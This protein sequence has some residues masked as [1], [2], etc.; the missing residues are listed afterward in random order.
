MF[1]FRFRLQLSFF[2]FCA[3]ILSVH[4]QEIGM[5][6]DFFGYVDNREFQAPYT[7][8][9]TILGTQLS[10]QLYLK[11]DENHY[12]YGGINYNQDFGKH[13]EN[14]SRFNPIA[15]YNYKSEKI[16]FALGFIPRYERLK[17]IPK[18]VL[19]DTFM[20]DRPNIEGMYFQY[21]GDNFKQAVFIDWLSEQ[22]YSHREQFVAGISGF[23]KWGLLYFKNDGLLYHNALTSNDEIDEHIQDNAV[24][25]GRLGLD[26]SD[27][28]FLDSLT[29]DAGIAF[30]FDRVRTE[31]EMQIKKGFISEQHLGYKKFG[32]TNTLYLGQA[33][34]LPNGDPFYHRSSYDR[35][36]LSWTPFK[37]AAI[38]GKFVASFHFTEG[39]VDNQQAFT[40]R[41]TFGQS[42]WR[43]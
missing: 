21:K 26:L 24:I 43:K 40:L 28:T 32:L 29:I 33:V 2:F 15:Y 9:K 17:E 35:L 11:L 14:K 41:Y 16:D 42:L 19:A 18:L 31:Y 27:R 6:L 8:P 1:P 20:Y 39:Q 36:D 7:I 10:P 3:S 12:V 37:T 23:Y 5:K 13:N 38:E 30:G 34:N 4:A 22:S 25:T